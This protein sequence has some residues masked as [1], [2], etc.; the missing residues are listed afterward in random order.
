MGFI[1]RHPDAPYA[2]GDV[3]QGD[4][5]LEPDIA[6][7]FNEY[8]GRLSRVN[9]ATASGT[10]VIGAKFLDNSI[11]GSKLGKR[12][13]TTGELTDQS[14]VSTDATGDTMTTSATL[15]NVPTVTSIS[16]TPSSV[17]DII[18]VE[19]LANYKD[20]VDTDYF[21]TFSIT[22]TDLGILYLSQPETS[23]GFV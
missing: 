6:N 21:W 14:D 5:D 1:A 20:A 22:G 2:T 9:F 17:K 7:L 11:P 18:L 4:T 13:L 16:V 3:V 23:G 19:F 15:V 12:V 8:N 10:T